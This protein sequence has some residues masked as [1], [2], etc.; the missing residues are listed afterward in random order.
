MTKNFREN[1]K[2]I[3]SFPLVRLMALAFSQRT[4]IWS[5]LALAMISTIIPTKINAAIEPNQAVQ[6]VEEPKVI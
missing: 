5:S 4:L 3:K 1:T 6:R 2:S